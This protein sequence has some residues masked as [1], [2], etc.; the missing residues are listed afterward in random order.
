MPE[1]FWK[2]YQPAAPGASNLAPRKP[3]PQIVKVQGSPYAHLTRP[4]K[5]TETVCRMDHDFEPAEE[6]AE[7]CPFCQRDSKLGIR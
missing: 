6:G 4:L 3:R 7:V 2:G 5:R 1:E